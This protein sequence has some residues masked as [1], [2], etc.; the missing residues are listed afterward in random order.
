MIDQLAVILIRGT[1]RASKEIV[2]T[3]HMLKLRGKNQ[4]V[5]ISKTPGNNGM[6]DKVKDYVTWG[7]I[8][9]EM[10]EMIKKRTQNGVSY[11]HPPRKG[12][13]RKGVKVHFNKGGA[14][15]YRGEKINDL[16][17]RMM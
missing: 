10:A 5:I 11:M 14:L 9:S 4:C 3:L 1:I 13:G 12:F 17:K 6:V 2:D 15:G 16:L 7:E 8:N